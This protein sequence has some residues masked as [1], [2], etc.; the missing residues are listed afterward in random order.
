MI[1]LAVLLTLTLVLP[2]PAQGGGGTTPLPGGAEMARIP[3]GSYLPHYSRDRTPVTIRSFEIDRHP[4]TRG[5]YLRF[6]TAR[7][8]WRR[9]RVKPLFAAQGYLASWPGALEIGGPEQARLPVASVSW[10]AARAYCEWEGKRLPTTDE[11]EYVAR[12]SETRRDATSDSAFLQRLTELSISRRPDRPI[13]SG[14]RNV[15]GVGDMH[16][17]VAEWVLDFNNVTVPDD[18]RTGPGGHDRQLYCAAGGMAATNPSDYPAF[19]RYATRA[20]LDG[21]STVGSLGFRCARS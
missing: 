20:G 19:L 12:A 4:V 14:F 10:F 6:V 7:P 11:W 16:G 5:D 9:D 15:Y 3:E 8:E 2:L 17:L 1:I 21:R 13:G 18:S